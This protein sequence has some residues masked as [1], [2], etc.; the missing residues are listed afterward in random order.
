MT[1][2]HVIKG[3]CS[4]RVTIGGR[5]YSGGGV[6]PWYTVGTRDLDAADVGTLKLDRP[7]PGHVFSFARRTPHLK[8]TIAVIGYPL[9]N[10]IS[11]NQGP[12]VFAQ[13]VGG[14]PALGVRIATAKGSS[15]SAFLNP[16]GD[17]VGILQRGL[18]TASAGIVVGVNLV[19]WWGPAILK[20]LCRAYPQAGVPGCAGTSN[21]PTNCRARDRAYINEL[22]GP[23]TTFVK[24]WNAW[25]DAGNPAD[26]SAAPAID[27]LEGPAIRSIEHQQ[28]ACSGGAKSVAS[29]LRGLLPL[30][31]QIEAALDPLDPVRL[32]SVLRVVDA[33]LD[34]IEAEL[35]LLGFFGGG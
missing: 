3:G 12:L 7:A 2:W 14:V 28:L 13:R 4:F 5:S 22:R 29:L 1:A 6:T 33:R 11:F 34:V 32:D 9:G 21:E 23:W 24:R 15:G 16:D 10:P 26:V 19:R 30:V 18:V 17:V 8:T 20:D 31:D 25:I 35:R 27:A